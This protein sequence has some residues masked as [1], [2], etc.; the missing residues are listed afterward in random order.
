MTLKNFMDVF[1]GSATFRIYD[2]ISCDVEYFDSATKEEITAS[3]IYNQISGLEIASVTSD[4][5][6]VNIL[7]GLKVLDEKGEWL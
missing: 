3:E 7:I 2:L 6:F 4:P 5:C 1:S